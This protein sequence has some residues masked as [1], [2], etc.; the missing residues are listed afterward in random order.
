MQIGPET[1]VLRFLTAVCLLALALS[2]TSIAAAADEAKSNHSLGMPD[3][4]ATQGPGNDLFR[5]H[6]AACHERAVDRAPPRLVLALMSPASIVHAL[7]DGPMRA[8]GSSLT[9]QQKVTVAE[10]I[11]Q[12]SIS[13]ASEIPDPP[14]CSGAAL[15]FDTHEPPVFPGWGLSPGN[16]RAIPDSTAMLD[17]SQL[18]RLQL[19]WVLA[20]PSA[21]RVRSEPALAGGAVYVG[22]DSGTVYSLDRRTGCLRWKFVAAA[23]SRGGI[24]V[25]PW[26]AGD[27]HAEPL[28]YFGDLLGN[29]YALR[30]RSGQLVWRDKPE[31]HPNA[32]ITAAPALSGNRV[33]VTV[34][35]NEEGMIDPHYACCT[36]RGSVVAYDTH[37]GKRLWQTFAVDVPTERGTNALGTKRLG[38]SGAPIWNTPTIDV[39]RKRLY[40]G[41][42]DNYSSPATTTSD[43]VLALDIDS[44][45]IL[46]SKQ[47]TSG[48]FWNVTCVMPDRTHCS[49]TPGPDYDIGATT[50]LNTAADG[51]ERLLVGQKSGIVFALEPDSGNILWQQRVGRGGA[52]GGIMFGMAAAA[53]TLIVPVGDVQDGRPYNEPSAPG[54]YALDVSNGAFRWKAPDT[55]DR[56]AGRAGCA[57]G[58]GQA[59]TIS[60]DLVIAGGYDGWLRI[61]DL[62]DGRVLWESDTVREFPALGGGTAHGGSMGGAAGPLVYRGS[63]L[64]SSGYGATERMPGNA[65]LMFGLKPPTRKP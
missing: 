52:L 12:K 11:T 17:R 48:D 16:G 19:N 9:A 31:D 47:L 57:P 36:F 34:S 7:E 54:I 50:I 40:V 24:V 29:V 38:P 22:S 51:R 63:L 26:S 35:S 3:M 59:V 43:A 8:Q 65:L 42:G 33:F 56:C 46:W 37:T 5:E 58:N 15:K 44:G 30:A 14:L 10:Y 27:V 18:A 53:D 60:G 6:C 55:A 64:V 32:T 45:K 61:H 49:G 25:T 23:E 41:T 4:G 39:K 62:R 2:A 21:I 20:L 13:T 1:M 28:L